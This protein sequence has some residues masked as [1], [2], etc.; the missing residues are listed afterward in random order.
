MS[1]VKDM[2][3]VREQLRVGDRVV[4]VDG[5]DMSKKKAVDVSSE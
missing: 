3:P 1:N 5:K 2:C 4:A